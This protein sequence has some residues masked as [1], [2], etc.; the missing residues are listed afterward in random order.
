MKTAGSY[1][2]TRKKNRK[3]VQPSQNP[4]A[5]DGVNN[6]QNE[7]DDEVEQEKV[8]ELFPSRPSFKADVLVSEDVRR[9]ADQC[10]LF[11]GCF[12]SV[13]CFELF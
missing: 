4:H 11:H 6:P 2:E 13:R 12:L 5:D 10:S 8:S 7:G 1:T 9:V 3:T